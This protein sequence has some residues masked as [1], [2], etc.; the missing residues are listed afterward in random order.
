MSA[1]VKPT[2][3]SPGCDLIL[4]RLALTEHRR[5]SAM[6][7]VALAAQGIAGFPKGPKVLAYPRRS[8]Q[9]RQQV[10]WWRLRRRL[11]AGSSSARESQ[12]SPCFANAAVGLSASW[13]FAVSVAPTSARPGGFV[14]LGRECSGH[15]L[16]RPSGPTWEYRG[17]GS[18]TVSRSGRKP[19]W[20]MASGKRAARV[21]LE[22]RRSR[23]KASGPS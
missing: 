10:C 11:Q 6:P 17:S 8:S 18:E 16:D 23:K 15:A 21:V 20:R 3:R 19:S 4:L 1:F 9:L 14:S 2:A 12:T 22:L 13:G 7:N 5:D